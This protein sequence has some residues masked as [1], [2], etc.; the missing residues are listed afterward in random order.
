MVVPTAITVGEEVEA[1]CSRYGFRLRQQKK[2]LDPGRETIAKL[3]GTEVSGFPSSHPLAAL[4]HTQ[5]HSATL[6]HPQPLLV[7]GVPR[8]H[9]WRIYLICGA[10]TSMPYDLSQG[11][12]ILLT[13]DLPVP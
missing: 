2:F 10:Y 5:P 7:L 13:F 1:T 11:P 3:S 12:D 4:S 8:G 9:L 6:S